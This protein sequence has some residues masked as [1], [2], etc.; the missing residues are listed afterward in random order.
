[1]LYPKP[2]FAAISPRQE[3]QIC[4][5]ATEPNVLVLAAEGNSDDLDVPIEAAFADA[6]FRRKARLGSVNSVNILRVLTQTAHIVWT[7]LRCSE[8]DSDEVRF[9][10]P[11]GAA[12]HLTSC[13]LARKMGVN[14][15]ATACTNANEILV[16]FVEQG[17]LRAR[18]AVLSTLSPSMDIA[19]PYNIERVLHLVS[20]GDAGLVRSWMH[21]FKA[22]KELELG[23]DLHGALR[24][25]FGV[26]ATKTTDAEVL[27]AIRAYSLD[28]APPILLDPHTAVAA[29]AAKEALE[30]SDGLGGAA[31]CVVMACAHPAKFPETVVKAVAPAFAS[32]AEVAAKAY[33]GQGDANPNQAVEDLEAHVGGEGG[34]FDAAPGV[35]TLA[36][37]TDWTA[38]LQAAL[39]QAF[40]RI[41]AWE[42]PAEA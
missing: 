22:G 40:P 18:D 32:W 28:A 6:A 14:L 5:R 13:I 15:R 7:Y 31:A 10:V 8:T 2:G 41:S 19:V 11:T 26:A 27:A 21:D 37:G 42:A 25:A 24:G 12:G 16:E 34:N 33:G 35:V 20:G 4:K 3:Y 39:E 30:G 17:R 36:R 29:H 1:M 38:G 23:P 9:F